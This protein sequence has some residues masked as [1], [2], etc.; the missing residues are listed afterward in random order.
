MPSICE[1]DEIDFWK[2]AD[3]QLTVPVHS[4]AVRLLYDLEVRG[5]TL[6]T[7]DADIVARPRCLLTD[8][9]RTAIRRLKPHI[10]H[11]LTYT[12]PAVM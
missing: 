2:D 6:T 10:W 12:P 4:A 1:R 7:D 9:D 11:V 5:I 3:G 8:T